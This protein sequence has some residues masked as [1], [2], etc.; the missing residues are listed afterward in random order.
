MIVFYDGIS[1]SMNDAFFAMHMNYLH[2]VENRN[3]VCLLVGQF[4]FLIIA[5][6]FLVTGTVYITVLALPKE[7]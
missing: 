2:S 5:V 7:Y 4:V 6:R 3:A 1:Q